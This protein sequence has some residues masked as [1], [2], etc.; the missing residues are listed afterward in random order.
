M[1]AGS[2]EQ[3]ETSCEYTHCRPAIFFHLLISLEINFGSAMSAIVASTALLAP[4]ASVRS[5]QSPT[6]VLRTFVAHRQQLTVRR[7]PAQWP[8]QRAGGMALASAADAS[9]DITVEEDAVSCAVD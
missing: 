3:D 1:V 8:A 2:L 6:R 4:L 7:W 5:Q 9:V